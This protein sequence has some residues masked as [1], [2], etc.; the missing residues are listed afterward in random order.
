MDFLDHLHGFGPVVGPFAPALVIQVFGHPE[1]FPL[2]CGQGIA[3][4]LDPVQVSAYDVDIGLYG[5]VPL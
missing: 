3:L 2:F 5:L 4:R 1:A